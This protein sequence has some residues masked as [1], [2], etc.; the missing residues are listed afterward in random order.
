MNLNLRVAAV[1]ISGQM[2]AKL[3]TVVLHIPPSLP[4]PPAPPITIIQFTPHLLPIPLLA[5]HCSQKGDPPHAADVDRIFSSQGSPSP[6]FS[7]RLSSDIYILQSTYAN[8]D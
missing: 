7:P 2:G 6:C 1:G 3:A 4:P 5:R 8:N